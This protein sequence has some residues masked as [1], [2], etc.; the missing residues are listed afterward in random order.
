MPRAVAAFLAVAITLTT[1]SCGDG[2]DEEGRKASADE[3]PAE[4]DGPVFQIRDASQTSGLDF[5]LRSG[6][7]EQRY[8]AEVK[9]TGVG[10][11]DYDGDGRLDVVLVAGS[12][13][14]RVRDKTAG[15][16]TRL[17]RNL[18]GLRFEDVTAAAG[19]PETEWACAPICADYDGDGDT[20]IYITSLGRNRLFRNDGGRFVDATEESGLGDEGWGTSAVFHDLDRD[21]DLDLYVCNYLAFDFTDPPEHGKPGLNCVWKEFVVMCG[22][23]GLP[24]Q[25]DRCFRN[26]GKGRFSDVT[27]AWGFG[28]QKAAYGLGVMAGDFDADGS[29]ELYVANDGMDNNWFEWNGKAFEDHA[30]DKGVACS[31]GGAPQAGMGLAAVDIN[32]DGIDDIACT[33]FSGEVNNLYISLGPEIYIESSALSGTVVGAFDNLGWGVGLVDFDLDGYTDLFVANGHVYPQA[34]RP[35]TS[36]DYPQFNLLF[37]GGANTHFKRASRQDHPGMAVKKVSRGAAFG[38]LDDDGD[39]DVIVANLNDTCTLLE[40]RLDLSRSGRHF[41]GVKLR[42]KGLNPDAIGARVTAVIGER[43]IVREVRRNGSFQSSNDPRILIG[44]GQVDR[45]DKLS[46]RWPDGT[47]ERFEVAVD[48]YVELRY[49]GGKQ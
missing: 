3:S 1:G 10:L 31:E 36:T 49:G 20:D 33:N 35:M 15:Y 16:G 32:D 23:K 19:I 40:T 41:L 14:E 44:L 9:S 7:A 37:L 26:D 2:A 30:Y 39:P 18:G 25:P 42:G 48:R 45:V 13:T 46:V 5:V 17:Y 4:S 8:I 43:R 29:V 28:A 38:D 21:G 12:T 47:V 34:A 6:T 11:L 27:D 24:A 22:P